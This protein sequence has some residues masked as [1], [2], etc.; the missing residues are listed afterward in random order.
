M[1]P[2]A[3]VMFGITIF[4]TFF[5]VALVMIITNL[6]RFDF[7]YQTL[8]WIRIFIVIGAG[9]LWAIIGT[10]WAVVDSPTEEK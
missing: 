5:S 10:L 8:F 7:T 2:N 4:A 1:R 6:D 9:L 3:T